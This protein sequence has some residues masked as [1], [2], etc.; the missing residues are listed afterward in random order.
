MPRRP[1]EEF[2]GAIHHV[3]ARGNDRREIFVDDD[4]RHAYIHLL[5]RAIRTQAWHCLGYC[6]MDNHVHLL[7]ETPKPNL[8]RGMQRLHSRYAELLNGRQQRV[9]H[10]FQGRY[11]AV[12]VEHDEQLWAVVA[13]IARN[14]VTA[15]LCAHPREWPWS[16]HAAMENRGSDGVIDAARLLDHFGSAGGDPRTRYLE[17]VASAPA[18]QGASV[19]GRSTARRAR[20]SRPLESWKDVG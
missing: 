6:L 1:R 18:E 9:G 7:I 13:Y 19:R 8:G 11:G 17:C 4:D 3:Y 20:V 12:R 2:P 5:R 16:S 10:V 14:P 15:G